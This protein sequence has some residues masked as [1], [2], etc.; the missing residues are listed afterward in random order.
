MGEVSFASGHI[1]EWVINGV[2]LRAFALH[3]S[4][5][6]CW[7]RPTNNS[8]AYDSRIVIA[9]AIAVASEPR[10]LLR[11]AHSPFNVTKTKKKDIEN[12]WT[13]QRYMTGPTTRP[14]KGTRHLLFDLSVSEIFVRVE[15]K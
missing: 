9:I 2:V 14:R 15:W 3:F 4:F 8:I 6:L 5:D 13:L 10:A 7:E 1:I 12:I 11:I